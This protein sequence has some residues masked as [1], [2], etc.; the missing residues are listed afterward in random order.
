MLFE[1][2]LT[3]LAKQGGEYIFDSES[4]VCLFLCPLGY[5][6]LSFENYSLSNLME[7][8]LLSLV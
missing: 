1:I 6:C 4:F 5:K 3:E 2:W 7:T 8:I